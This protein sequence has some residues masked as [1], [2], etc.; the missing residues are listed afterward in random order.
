MQFV[1]E[2]RLSNNE[3][4]TRRLREL[5]LNGAL[6]QGERVTEAGLAELLQ[7]SRTPVR[8]ALAVLEQEDLVIG[9]PNRGFHVRRF[10]IDDMHDSIEVRSTLEG[11]AARLAA[12]KGL[13]ADQDAILVDCIE[14]VERLIQEQRLD[15]TAFRTFSDY[16]IR[17]HSTIA[18]AAANPALLR[19]IERNPFRSAPLLHILP[20]RE[21]LATLEEA[22]RGHRRLLEVIRLRQGTRAEFLMRE[23]AL[24]PLAKAEQLFEFINA[25][26]EKHHL[27]RAG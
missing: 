11:M 20:A 27:R 21:A 26:A 18:E 6:P 2:R 10:T 9:S 23:H 17:F 5:I 25:N 24:L 12:E 15:E 1:E 8:L 4:V 13:S 22:Q 3:A 16:N 19:T 14:Q 7:V